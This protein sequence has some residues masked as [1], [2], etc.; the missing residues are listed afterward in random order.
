MK[1]VN[2]LLVYFLYALPFIDL[3]TSMATWESKPSIG[4]FLKGLFVIITSIYVF[5]QNRQKRLYRYIYGLFIIYLLL[6]GG[7]LVLNKPDTIFVELINI[8]KIFYF[9]FLALFFSQYKNENINKKLFFYYAVCFLFLYLIPYPFGLGHNI[10]EIY[11]NKSLYLSYFYVGNELVNIFILILPIGYLYLKEKSRIYLL[12]YV[13]IIFL[14]ML[15]LGTKTMYFSVVLLLLYGIYRRKDTFVKYVKRNIKLLLGVLII[16]IVLFGFMFP[17]TTFY[18]NIKTT[19]NYYQITSI[20]DIFTWNNIDNVLYSHRLTFVKDL[21]NVYQSSSFEQK[22]LGIGRQ[23]IIS[24]KDAEI[25]I[26]D[27]FYSIGILGMLLYIGLFIVVVKKSSLKGI[28]AYLFWLLILIS[29][30]SGHVLLSPMT[31]TYLAIMIGINYNE[32]RKNNEK[33]DS[34]SI[35]TS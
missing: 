19:L 26:F 21:H 2:K 12:G 11:E 7:Y 30:F 1:K 4:L 6:Y 9:P 15:L 33:M 13:I 34:K 3:L 32:G 5:Y 8:T 18:K 16:G 23:K 29:M 25:D 28:Y 35:K 17:Q 31:S 22:I 27:I 14:M 10:N 20:S 24:L